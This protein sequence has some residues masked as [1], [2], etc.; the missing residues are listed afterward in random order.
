[1]QPKINNHISFC[2]VLTASIDPKGMSLV[3]RDNVLV[4]EQDYIEVIQS[5]I[6]KPYAVV[7]C[8][9]SGYSLD[10][11]KFCLE[12]R[13]FKFNEVLQFDGQ[14]FPRHLGK[15]YGELMILEYATAQSKLIATSDY[16]VKITGR[17]K[18][19]NLDNVLESIHMTNAFVIADF[20]PS[21]RYTYSGVFICKP[22]F[23]SLYLNKYK[24]F[25]DDSKNQT[26]EVAL[27]NAIKDAIRDGY[28]CIPFACK[29]VV[30][31]YSG[32][33]NVEIEKNN[34]N[35][36]KMSIP[37]MKMILKAYSREFIKKTMR[38]WRKER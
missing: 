24:S 11:I 19:L 8:E 38:V 3:K 31:G 27:H 26:M 1:M 29:P 6:S 21:G 18:V 9:N 28:E 14:Q 25:L 10:A 15:G 16:V 12:K 17:Y 4:R 34:F 37:K 13:T 33:W 22:A 23:I 35:A 7:F 30:E 20:K 36:I 5:L 32:T 2:I